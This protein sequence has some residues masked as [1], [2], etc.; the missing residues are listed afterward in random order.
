MR[1]SNWRPEQFD[2]EFMNASM[3]RLRDAAEVIA[4]KAK[5]NLAS[6]I[7][8]AVSRP[9]YKTGDYANEP[10]TARE[11][12]SLLKS[13][14]IV[15]KKETYGTLMATFRNIRVYVGNYLVYYA[16]PFEYATTRK[17][18]K[19]FLRPALNASKTEIKSI[20]ENGK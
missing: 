14:R 5:S 9:P 12:G 20:L 6:A 19:A 7:K 2:G 17:R 3:D 10:W 8:H 4:S 15:E 16:L 1:V 13:V 11:A 18:G